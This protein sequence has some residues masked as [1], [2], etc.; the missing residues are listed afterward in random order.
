MSNNKRLL[1]VKS[2]GVS[3][4]YMNSTTI[5]PMGWTFLTSIQY[6]TKAVRMVFL[7][8]F[9]LGSNLVRGKGPK[10]LELHYL[11]AD[12]ERPS[13]RRKR[14]CPS[15]PCCFKL[16]CVGGIMLNQTGGRW[17]FFTAL[18]FNSDLFW[19]HFQRH[20][21]KCFT[22]YLG[23]SHPGNLHAQVMLHYP[24]YRLWIGQCVFSSGL[25]H[26]YS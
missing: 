21:Q 13:S 4:L 19:K 12:D 3:S 5:W 10:N 18:Q 20:M 7:P 2:L 1:P 22:T 8:C 9:D 17:V 26:I 16:P 6:N 24:F 11:G 25:L 23:I 15:S 14:I